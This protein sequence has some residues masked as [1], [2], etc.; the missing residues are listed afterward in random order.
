MLSYAELR[1]AV[2]ILDTMIRGAVV[3]RITQSDD[4]GLTFTF[5]ASEG[6]HHL[7]LCCHPEFARLSL[8]SE[9]PRAVA[10]PHTFQQYC[11]AH[12]TKAAFYDAGIESANRQVSFRLGASDGMFQVILSILGARSNIYL[13]DP[14]GRLSH[15]LRPL[16][17]TRRE[18]AL[19]SL[20]TDPAGSPPSSS[21]DRWESS[22]DERFFEDLE[23]TCRREERARAVETLVRKLESTLAKEA[24][25]LG[26]KAANLQEDLGETRAADRSRRLGELLKGILHEV[27]P[28]A[29]K[30][31]ATDFATGET[32]EIALD[33]QL[34]PSANLEAYFAR[35]QKEV[36]SSAAI[37]EQIDSVRRVQADV[38]AM[39]QELRTLSAGTEPDIDALRSFAENPRVRRLLQRY[40]PA[41]KPQRAVKKAAGRAEIPGKLLPK[42]Y[43]TVDGLE[44]WVGRS[45]EGND[46]LTTRLARGNDLFFHLEGYPGSHVILRTE[47]R[48]DP[49]AESVLAACELAVHFS[50][51]KNDGH[52]DVH[53]A[54]VKNVKKPKGAKRGLVYVTRGKTV[55]LR[56]DPKR[57]EETLASRLDE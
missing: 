42:R 30:V 36:R 29:A 49:P 57:L 16:E 17:D 14:Q 46:Y 54:S 10:S 19:G 23:R 18:L 24:A 34:S 50:K 33:P 52:A 3:H 15:A 45:D 27:G 25:F 8:L 37:E 7:F 1:R 13:L 47:G 28:G 43:R 53:V 44:I 20:W 32:V 40:F 9:P 38:D 41:R 2:R 21:A 11:R 48:S 35:Y 56:R 4:Y 6:E 12:L 51:L 39:Q 31:S 5:R 55:H 26:R 22:T